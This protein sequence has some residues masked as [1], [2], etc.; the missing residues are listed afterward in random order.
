MS[1]SIFT[2]KVQGFID[3]FADA[4]QPGVRKKYLCKK[5]NVTHSFEVTDL[6]PHLLKT[7]QLL[8]F[9]TFCIDSIYESN[10]RDLPKRTAMLHVALLDKLDANL[11]HLSNRIIGS[12]KA[13]WWFPILNFFGYVAKAPEKLL[14]LQKKVE[15]LA[16]WKRVMMSEIDNKI[17]PFNWE[18]LPPKG[19]RDIVFSFLSNDDLLLFSQAS[20]QSRIAAK[21]AVIANKKPMKIQW[22]RPEQR[23]LLMKRA[24]ALGFDEEEIAKVSG[25]ELHK[26]IEEAEE[27]NRCIKLSASL[28]CSE[29]AQNILFNV[30]QQVLGPRRAESQ[31]LGLNLLRYRCE[32]FNFIDDILM[33]DALNFHPPVSDILIPKIGGKDLI[34]IGKEIEKF[35]ISAS[36]QVK[37]LF[38]RTNW[39]STSFGKDL[40][41]LPKA[42]NHFKHLESL[43]IESKG[44]LNGNADNAAR[45]VGLSSLPKL[46][47]P[48][49]RNLS[50]FGTNISSLPV[51]NLPNLE[52]CDL[53]GNNFR[54]M[55][56]FIGNL[57]NLN[58]INITVGFKDRS[59]LP[60]TELEHWNESA[61]LP[62]SL[63]RLTVGAARKLGR[64]PVSIG[65]LCNLTSLTIW[66]HE[67]GSLDHEQAQLSIPPSIIQLS[68][69]EKLDFQ[70]RGPNFREPNEIIKGSSFGGPVGINFLALLPNLKTFWWSEN[71]EGLQQ[72]SFK[73]IPKHY[74]RNL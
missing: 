35:F 24:L 13:R 48:K 45:N 72:R 57:P 73:L 39:R 54:E 64:I 9:S 71:R 33:D 37:S 51:M 16:S 1:S 56:S 61:I 59:D 23:P 11:K 7:D 46:D 29:I 55:P 15:T 21:A 22:N 44:K 60:Y 58:D 27:A 42:I 8:H 30:A 6:K 18:G 38:I 19:P 43:T 25:E 68:N 49:L 31:F 41:I 63:K 34:A 47:L 17:D 12:I 2:E 70:N 20:K 52:R 3:A 53:E 14:L 5:Q 62:T 26:L 10:V 65:R 28:P 66:R 67:F 4:M 69:L 40:D 74:F 36:S 32:N 50:I